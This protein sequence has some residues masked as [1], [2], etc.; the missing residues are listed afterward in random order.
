MNMRKSA[1]SWEVKMERI[2]FS[3][4]TSLIKAVGLTFHVKIAHKLVVQ[5][6]ILDNDGLVELGYINGRNVFHK[7]TDNAWRVWKY[8]LKVCDMWRNEGRRQSK[9]I[10]YIHTGRPVLIIDF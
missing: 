5:V 3:L 6:W 9:C 10:R 7:V 1:V 2:R 4:K 8:E